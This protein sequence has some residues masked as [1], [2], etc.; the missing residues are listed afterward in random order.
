MK[1]TN[2]FKA[3]K[4]VL[5]APVEIEDKK[6]MNAVILQ[7]MIIERKEVRMYER[8]NSAKLFEISGSILTYVIGRGR[9]YASYK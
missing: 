5:T 9:G 6:Y 3:W 8:F 7:N 1:I 4:T 2:L